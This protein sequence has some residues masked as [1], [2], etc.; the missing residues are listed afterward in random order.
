MIFYN[1]AEVFQSNAAS[2]MR[3]ANVKAA[4]SKR[5]LQTDDKPRKAVVRKG[6]PTPARN[7]G[8]ESRLRLRGGFLHMRQYVSHVLVE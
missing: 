2:L 8:N 4:P 7:G 1:D 3:D 5:R 6:A